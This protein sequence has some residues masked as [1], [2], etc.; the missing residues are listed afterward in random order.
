VPS[1]FLLAFISALY[2]LGAGTAIATTRGCQ[3]VQ[4]RC[5][6][7]VGGRCN[8]RTGRWWGVYQ[9]QTCGG[10]MNGWLACLDRVRATRR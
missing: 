6:I 4:A 2:L 5:A 1:K 7:E 9:H 3:S 10:T 8:P